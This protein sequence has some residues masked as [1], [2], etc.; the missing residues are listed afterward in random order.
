M[1]NARYHFSLGI[2]CV[3]MGKVKFSLLLY[4]ENYFKTNCVT[5]DLYPLIY[6]STFV[7]YEVH[8]HTWIFFCS[9]FWLMLK[10]IPFLNP[11]HFNHCSFSVSLEL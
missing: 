5:G 1:L 6:K 8:I 3:F 2:Y 9:L 4:I 7:I 10:S 11:L